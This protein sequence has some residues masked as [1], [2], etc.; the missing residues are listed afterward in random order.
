MEVLSVQMVLLVLV[1]AMRLVPEHGL[2]QELKLAVHLEFLDI[3]LVIHKLQQDAT[4]IVMLRLDLPR[5]TNWL[6]VLALKEHRFRL[7]RH[8]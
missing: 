5:C 4:M 1:L 2:L 6:S 7:S 3:T 8:K